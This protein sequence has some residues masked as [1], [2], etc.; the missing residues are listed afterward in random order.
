MRLTRLHV[1]LD[2]TPDA[3]FD[4]PSAQAR[5]AVQVLRLE[6]TVNSRPLPDTAVVP[7]N[8]S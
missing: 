2:L 6:R 1:D 7:Q 4:L 8:P 5:H 3:E